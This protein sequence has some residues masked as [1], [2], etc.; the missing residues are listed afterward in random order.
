MKKKVWIVIACVL[1]LAAAGIAAFFAV[2]CAA[3]GRSDGASPQETVLETLPPE[4]AT[5]LPLD[6]EP[7]EGNKL[8]A[9]QIEVN[10]IED[11]ADPAGEEQPEQKEEPTEKP[12]ETPKPEST[13]KPNTEQGSAGAETRK[14]N[15]TPPV[16]VPLMD[17]D[18]ETP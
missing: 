8:E 13:E 5:E 2:R 18:E 11:P 16:E 9:P 10:V 1:V 3:K 14:D 6:E 4:D 7:D 12:S 15:D 17:W